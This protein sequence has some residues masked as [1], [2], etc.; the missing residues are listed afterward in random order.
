MPARRSA[1][2]RVF[3]ALR[4]EITSS[5]RFCTPAGATDRAAAD[6]KKGKVFLCGIRDEEREKSRTD[7]ACAL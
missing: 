4:G 5:I 2:H 1:F 7:S 6:P 3:D